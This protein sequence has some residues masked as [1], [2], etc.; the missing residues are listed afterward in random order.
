ML[1]GETLDMAPIEEAPER[2]L[3]RGWEKAFDGGSRRTFYVNHELRAFSWE[4]V[5]RAKD[6]QEESSSEERA[7]DSQAESGTPLSFTLSPHLSPHII[8]TPTVTTATTKEITSHSTTLLQPHAS[9]PCMPAEHS[10]IILPCGIRFEQEA[11]LVKGEAKKLAR[12]ARQGDTAN[13]RTLLST[14]AAQ[15]VINYQDELGGTPL[16]R[17]KACPSI[18]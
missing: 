3:P 7:K 14:P 12:A 18:D 9:V 10:A 13:V 17:I 8:A 1:S 11:S 16:H 4:P 5:E 2:P 6:C 15:F